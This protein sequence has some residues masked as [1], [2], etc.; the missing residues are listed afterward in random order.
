AGVRALSGGA[1]PEFKVEL[2][3]GSSHSKS[4]FAEES[5]TNRG[6][7]VNA[8]GTVAFAATG[9]SQPG[10]GNVTIAGSNVGAND[11]ILA[12]KNQVNI[13]NTTD[14]DSTRSSNESKSSSVGVSVGTGGIGVS[15]AMSKAHGDGNSDLATQNNS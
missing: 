7:I 5:V 6:S 4:A 3:V 14:T 9:N 10:S 1:S 12:A 13:V 2:S 15:A 8:G 11:V